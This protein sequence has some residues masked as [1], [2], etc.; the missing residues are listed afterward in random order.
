MKSKIKEQ[1]L[2][3]QKGKAALSVD[4]MLAQLKSVPPEQL[5]TALEAYLQ[6]EQTDKRKLH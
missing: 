6:P 3:V 2:T 1:K 5:L 4:D